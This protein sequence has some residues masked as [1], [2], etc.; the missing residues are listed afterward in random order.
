MLLHKMSNYIECYCTLSDNKTLKKPVI[1]TITG[2][3]GSL[4]NPLLVEA[5]GVEPASEN[6][7]PMDLHVYSVRTAPDENQTDKAIIRSV[8]HCLTQ[9]PRASS[10]LSGPILRALDGQ[11]MGDLSGRVTYAA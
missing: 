9:V 8:R 11:V 6:H 2:F 3:Y 7:Q 1:T 10:S 5:A 4:Q